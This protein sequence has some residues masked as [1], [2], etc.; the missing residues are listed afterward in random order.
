MRW[1]VLIFWLPSFVW[2]EYR[3]FELRIVN[4]KTKKARTVYSTL[5]GI[6]YPQYHHLS[7]DERIEVLD[8]WMCWKRS[9]GMFK[10]LCQRPVTL[11]SLKAEIEGP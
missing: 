4:D 1:I 7:R 8:H 11:D 3:V 9:Y 10:P 6:Q 5:D 2:G